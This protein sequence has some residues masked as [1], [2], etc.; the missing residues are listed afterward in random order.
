MHAVASGRST[1]VFA[2]NPFL[3]LYVIF[4][5]LFGAD[6]TEPVQ[7]HAQPQIHEIIVVPGGQTRHLPRRV[8]LQ[9]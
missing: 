6:S 9:R 4:T 7:S 5:T 3:R 2:L 1:K 8:G